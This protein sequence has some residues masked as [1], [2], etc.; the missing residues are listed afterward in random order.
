MGHVYPVDDLQGHRQG[1]AT[2]LPGYGGSVS[3]A[4]RMNVGCQLILQDI[5]FGKAHLLHIRAGQD[6]RKALAVALEIVNKVNMALE[7]YLQ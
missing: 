2:V 1:L 6:G 5:G 4:N 7:K 3:G